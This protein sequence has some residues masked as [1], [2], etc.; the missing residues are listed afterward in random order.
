MQHTFGEWYEPDSSALKDILQTG[1][2]ALDANVLLDL[3]RTGSD[4]RAQILGVFERPEVRP[5]VW[6][7]YQVG[8]EFQRNRLDVARQ[9]QPQYEK[10]RVE[11]EKLKTFLNGSISGIRDTEVQ[12]S[13][14]GVVEEGL[15]AAAVS[16]ANHLDEQE[17]KHVISYEEIRVSDPLRIRLDGILSSASQIGP[18]PDDALIEERR[19]KAECRY[20]HGIPPGYRDSSKSDNADGDVLIWFEILDHADKADRPV[21]F[22]TSDVKA[23]WY[24]REAG[25][26]LGPRP[27]L[28]AEFATR[29][30]YPYHQV[31]LS[32]FLHLSNEYLG[33]GVSGETID[34]VEALAEDRRVAYRR[35]RVRVMLQRLKRASTRRD[36]LWAL[37]FY[38]PGTKEFGA[39][40]ALL[41]IVDGDAEFSAGLASHAFRILDQA[42]QDR[43]AVDGPE[44]RELIFQEIRH[45]LDMLEP[46]DDDERK[47]IDE[48][49]VTNKPEQF[50]DFL[51]AY[52]KMRN[53][54]PTWKVGFSELSSRD[55]PDRNDPSD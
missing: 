43:V 48:L 50:L 10:I 32:T 23:D 36:L 40:R 49:A 13:I 4:Q 21:L 12:K 28:R 51:Q 33:A 46:L 55:F 44:R 26:T 25:D 47:L 35:N 34:S 15:T 39:L 20:D 6:I 17:K 53:H 7:P 5:R 3:Y 29:S 45:H 14:R 1:T 41:E 16:I 27:E 30:A 8:L 52:V 31:R 42:L 18:R 38:G 2:I 9:H 37:D 19:K 54:S 24:R 22:V 11:L